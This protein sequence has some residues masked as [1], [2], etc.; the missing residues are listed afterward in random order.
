[1]KGAHS[2]QTDAVLRVRPKEPKIV[3]R[4]QGSKFYKA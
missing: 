4:N 3:Y 2:W 1:M